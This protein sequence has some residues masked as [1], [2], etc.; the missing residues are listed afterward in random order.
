VHAEEGDVTTLIAKI[1][2]V[3]RTLSESNAQQQLGGFANF[4]DTERFSTSTP[5]GETLGVGGYP[6]SESGP[7][8]VRREA[9]VSNATVLPVSP[10]SVTSNGVFVTA[11]S[12]LL[13]SMLYCLER[14]GCVRRLSGRGHFK[15]LGERSISTFEFSP[16]EFSKAVG[17]V[18]PSNSQRLMLCRAI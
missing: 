13:A 16:I 15:S 11:G 9:P 6:A 17:P 7:E 8:I 12:L 14:D 18:S 1:L 4:V 2:Q 5:G 3:A 10:V